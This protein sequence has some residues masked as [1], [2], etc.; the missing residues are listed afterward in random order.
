MTSALVG[1]TVTRMSGIGNRIVVLDLRGSGLTISVE[2]VRAI[3]RAPGLGFDQLMALFDS[4]RQDADAFMRIY[5]NDGS[6]AGACGNGTRC[7]AY[8]MLR[9]A[10]M[11]AVALSTSAGVLQCVRLSDDRFCVDMGEPR[12]KWSEIPLREP[13]A[14][15][16]RVDLRIGAPKGAVPRFASVVNMGNPHAVFFVETF[17]GIDL[18]MLG[19][20]IENHP[21]FPQKANVSF[22]RIRARDAVE[23]K[24]WE[25]GVG[26]TLACGSAACATL[27]AA[28]RADLT[29]R[30]ARV[31][32]PGG[33][34]TIEWRSG[35]NHVLMTGPVAFEYEATLNASMF[36]A[37]A[38]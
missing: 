6:E 7:V 36:E 33:D 30:I 13:A 29:D 16:R 32:L 5:N 3:D 25:R 26:A 14:D 27:V 17:A 4:H 20:M 10:S 1:R 34:L 19:P 9:G 18:P 11:D 23:L 15:T 31:S 8:L 2:E 22:A 35:D 28:R 12:L 38:A 24:V 21:M 37:I